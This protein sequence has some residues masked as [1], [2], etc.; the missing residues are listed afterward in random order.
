LIDRNITDIN[1]VIKALEDI[2]RNTESDDSLNTLNELRII[3]DFLM[4]L[5]NFFD[6]D[7]KELNFT[8][9]LIIT[10]GFR[11]TTART[12]PRA[13]LPRRQYRAATLPRATLPRAT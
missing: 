13:T 10:N 2:G 8:I 1:D 6:S 11:D 5:Q 7:D 12:L 4:K 9:A 3:V